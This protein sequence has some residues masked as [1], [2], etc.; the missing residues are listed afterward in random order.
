MVTALLDCKRKYKKW[1][2]KSIE[3][4]LWIAKY[5][6]LCMIIYGCS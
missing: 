5:V 6:I 4:L 2:R 1:E 3:I